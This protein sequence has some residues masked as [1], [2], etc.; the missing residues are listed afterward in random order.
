MNRR[1][2]LTWVSEGNDFRRLRV[3]SKAGEVVEIAML[4]HDTPPT[5]DIADRFPRRFAIT[6]VRPEQARSRW[7]GSRPGV[8]ALSPRPAALEAGTAGAT[9]R[10]QEQ[11][12]AVMCGLPAKRNRA[13]KQLPSLSA[14]RPVAYRRHREP[15]WWWPA[16]DDLGC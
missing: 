12:E 14:L 1:P 2:R 16:R 4:T 8:G 10:V 13:L 15:S 7:N 6:E 11:Q 9:G 5:S 3:I